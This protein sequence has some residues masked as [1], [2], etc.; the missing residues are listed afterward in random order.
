[1]EETNLLIVCA[2]AFA[3]V[4][5][6]LALL[7]A[8]M[9]LMEAFFPEEQ[10]EEAAAAAEEAE[11]SVAEEVAVDSSI[12][13]GERERAAVSLAVLMEIE[14]EEA[15]EAARREEDLEPARMGWKLAGRLERM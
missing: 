2:T 8:L 1:M 10:P 7:A 12:E 14:K 9:R 4:V 6:L 15:A 13:R 3:A 5:L 11:A